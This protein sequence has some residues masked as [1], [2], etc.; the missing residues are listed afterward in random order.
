[1][2]LGIWSGDAVVAEVEIE[3]DAQA[4][5]ALPELLDALTRIAYSTSQSTEAFVMR[6][7]AK[8]ALLKAG[9][10]IED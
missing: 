8:Q 9:A 1:M 6:E 5:S 3:V 10:T 2:T 7:H 4:I